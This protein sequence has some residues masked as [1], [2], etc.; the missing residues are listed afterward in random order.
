MKSSRHGAVRCNFS[1]GFSCSGVAPACFAALT[2]GSDCLWQVWQARLMFS[3]GLR[4]QGSGT[5]VAPSRMQ[6]LWQFAHATPL[7]ACTPWLHHSNFGCCALRIGAPVP[8]CVSSKKRSPPLNSVS[9]RNASIWSTRVPLPQGK[10]S[11]LS[12]EPQYSTWHWAQ[13]WERNSVRLASA[14]GSQGAALPAARQRSTGGAK[15]VGAS[16]LR[17]FGVGQPLEALDD[18]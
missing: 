8:A 9:F 2:S 17:G 15:G 4:T 10:V 13:T 18:A 12:A 6:G 11:G 14:F 16:G 3:N 7:R 5:W 1:A